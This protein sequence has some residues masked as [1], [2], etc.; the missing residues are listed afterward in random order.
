MRR[1]RQHRALSVS[2]IALAL[3][4]LGAGCGGGGPA[5]LAI[6]S[7]SKSE[8]TDR[9]EAICADG[10]REAL[11]YQP[12]STDEAEEAVAAVIE[13]SV[14]PAITQAIDEIYAL[15]APTKEKKQAEAMLVSMEEA[16]ERTEELKV[17][18]VEEIEQLFAPSGR[19]ARKAG[20]FS[21]AYG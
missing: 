5:E 4:A 6:A 13:E 9:V 21:C 1:S 11:R 20:L 18:T 2:L 14:L 10:R 16:V 7:M 3:A 17:P 12:N 8:F 15:G 19:L